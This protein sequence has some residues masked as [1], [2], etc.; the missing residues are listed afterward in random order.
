METPKCL[1]SSR[2]IHQRGAG[3][4]AVAVPAL[5]DPIRRCLPSITWI[6]E[7][8]RRT[9][10]HGNSVQQV[11]GAFD[12]VGIP[13]GATAAVPLPEVT[14]YLWILRGRERPVAITWPPSTSATVRKAL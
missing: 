4:V 7:S 14:L 5:D 11:D 3:G 13:V 6:S 8:T 10:N 2:G 12:R 9:P 1:V